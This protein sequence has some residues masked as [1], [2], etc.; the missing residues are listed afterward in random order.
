[1]PEYVVEI[2]I[3]HLNVTPGRAMVIPYGYEAGSRED[4]VAHALERAEEFFPRFMYGLT[5][6]SVHEADEW[7]ELPRAVAAALVDDN[8]MREN[9]VGDLVCVHCDAWLYRQHTATCPVRMVQERLKEAFN[10]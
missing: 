2:V 5:V 6:Q 3:S 8:G 7:I 1:M 4:A 10:G 9:A